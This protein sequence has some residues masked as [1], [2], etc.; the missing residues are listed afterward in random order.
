VHCRSDVSLLGC[1]HKD[2]WVQEPQETQEDDTMVYFSSCKTDIGLTFLIMQHQN[3][4]PS[5]AEAKAT[6]SKE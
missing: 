5:E 4:F 3:A 6:W 2:F 1:Y